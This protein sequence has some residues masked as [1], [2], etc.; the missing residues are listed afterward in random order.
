LFSLQLLKDSLFYP[1]S[2]ALFGGYRSYSGLVIGF[3]SHPDS[4]GNTLGAILHIFSSI[5]YLYANT[6]SM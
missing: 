6:D 1:L 2:Q 4:L 3:F 5:P